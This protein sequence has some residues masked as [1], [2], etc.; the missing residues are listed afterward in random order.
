MQ[1]L[2]AQ[3]TSKLK[4]LK[5][6]LQFAIAIA[7]CNK[8]TYAH[9]VKTDIQPIQRLTALQMFARLSL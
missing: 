5:P 1:P 9:I 7:S 6:M 4:P 8:A 3:N 2:F